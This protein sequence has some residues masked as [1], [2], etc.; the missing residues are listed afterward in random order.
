MKQYA[1]ITLNSDPKL[2]MAHSSPEALKGAVPAW[3][4]G[5][6]IAEQPQ[7]SGTSTKRRCPS[8]E[9]VCEIDSFIAQDSRQ[10]VG[11]QLL[12][13]RP[14]SHRQREES[15]GELGFTQEQPR[16]WISTTVGQRPR[17]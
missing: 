11:P 4:W 3:W 7:R 16:G 15:C 6:T 13:R 1:Q 17:Q 2:H 10:P 12:M 9:L 8:P 5:R 14:R